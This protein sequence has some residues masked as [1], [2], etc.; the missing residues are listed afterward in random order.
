MALA[1]R[2]RSV[3]ALRNPDLSYL[4]RKKKSRLADGFSSK[5]AGCVTISSE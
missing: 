3:G 5:Q 4:A 2:D 1:K